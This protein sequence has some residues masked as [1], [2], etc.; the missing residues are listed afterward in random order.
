[1]A[2]S[3][4]RS[5]TSVA[6]YMLGRLLAEDLHVSC[7]PMLPSNVDSMNGTVLQGVC[8]LQLKWLP[9]L[10]V[11]TPRGTKV[12]VQN[13]AVRHGLLLL[14]PE[15]FLVLGA[16][17]NEAL[18][19]GKAL[20][21]PAQSE[22]VAS[23]GAY[24]AGSKEYQSSPDYATETIVCFDPYTATSAPTSTCNEAHRYH[25]SDVCGCSARSRS[26]S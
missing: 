2:S 9:T 13:V 26:S 24:A 5:A 3:S 6:N 23:S 22:C 10:S 4:I 1:M 7:R 20:V 15:T 11:A 16:S 8:L 18:D 14:T 17:G 25:S 19:V 12:I 21:G